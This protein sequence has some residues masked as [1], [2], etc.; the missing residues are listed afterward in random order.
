MNIEEKFNEFYNKFLIENR[1]NFNEIEVQ[2]K[3]SISERKRKKLLITLSVI[4]FFLLSVATMLFSNDENK[5][6]VETFGIFFM[7]IT[8]IAPMIIALTKRNNLKE[9]DKLYK[10]KIMKNLIKSF[11][12]S[13]QYYPNGGIAPEEF[14]KINFEYF[15]VFYSS[16]LIKGM[17]MNDEITISKVITQY[18]YHD[19]SNS[20]NGYGNYETFDGLF[21]KVKLPQ[22]SNIELYIKRKKTIGKKLF[23][24]FLGYIN[25]VSKSNA[26]EDFLKNNYTQIKISELNTIFNIYSSHPELI[27]NILDSKMNEILIDIY[28]TENFEISIKDNCIYMKFWIAGLFSNPPIEKETYDREIIYKNYKMLYIIFYL[29]SMFKKK[30]I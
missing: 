14:K 4:T 30:I 11:C 28:S 15:N 1:N 29:S 13:L 25:Q 22:K 19:Y 8:W 3:N 7:N 17:Y 16:N 24:I 27:K 12:S 5:E 10:E 6:T 21:A 2:R 18:S 26:E 9:Y 20:G 23:N